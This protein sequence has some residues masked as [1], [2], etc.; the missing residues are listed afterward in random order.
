M[1]KR[2]SG[3]R[4]VLIKPRGFWT[5]SFNES[6]SRH[7]WNQCSLSS[8]W[9]TP[10]TWTAIS[11]FTSLI[12]VQAEGGILVCWLELYSK[13]FWY[14][15]SDTQQNCMLV[16]TS[17]A[18]CARLSVELGCTQPYKLDQEENKLERLFGL[19]SRARDCM[20]RLH[21]EREENS[22]CHERM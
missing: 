13:Q 11:G 9:C 19:S 3:T 4:N 17:Y 14:A 18:A 8:A 22:C 12:N 2:K 1:L 21:D 7:Q 10:C 20:I 15:C 5:V 6:I 16:Q